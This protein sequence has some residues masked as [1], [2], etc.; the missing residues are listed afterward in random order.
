[1]RFTRTMLTLSLVPAF[2]AG[3][4]QLT[5]KD[6]RKE[7]QER[8]SQVRGR[9][10]LQVAQEH[11]RTGRLAEAESQLKDA[12]ALDPRCATA[13]VLIAR[14]SMERGELAAARNA[15]NG[16]IELSGETGEVAYLLGVLAEWSGDHE[17]ALACFQRSMERDGPS[18]TCIVARAE[19]LVA[20]KRSDEALDLIQR[21]RNDFA[22]NRAMSSL[23]G[24]IH[25][26]L[27]HYNEAVDAYRE[28]ALLAPA[29]WQAQMQYGT[30]LA[31]CGRHAE[32][33]RV[34]EPLVK[35]NRDLPASARLAL[36]RSYLELGNPGAAHAAFRQVCDSNAAGPEEWTWLARAALRQDD[37]AGAR[38]SAEKA[39]ASSTNNPSTFLLLAHVCIRQRDFEKARSALHACLQIDSGQWLAHYLMGEVQKATGRSS[40]AAFHYR[41]AIE[42]D[43]SQSQARQLVAQA[44]PASSR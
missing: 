33:V 20:L 6:S 1:M 9:M 15:L 43:P 39:C 21:H 44:L 38:Q 17:T 23:A 5:P 11:L 26:M 2:L 40:E 10:K 34:L 32:A 24:D 42:S 37:L 22:G 14:V 31:R 13:H 41:M 4:N 28:V 12:M 18:P 25:T 29:D 8:W 19:T 27:G 30:A 36:G 35:E 16:A 7:A 3:C